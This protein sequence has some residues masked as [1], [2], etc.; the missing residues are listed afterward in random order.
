MLLPRSKD[1]GG[2]MQMAGKEK[3]IAIFSDTCHG[4][5]ATSVT[6]RTTATG[7]VVHVVGAYT[8]ATGTYTYVFANDGTVAVQYAFTVTA[9]GKCDPRQIGVVFRLPKDCDQLTWRRKAQWSAYPDD[10]IG[11]PQGTATAFV[12]GV[13]L[14]GLAGPRTAPTW[15]WSADANQYGCNDF[16][17]TK[18]NVFEAALLSPGGKGVRVLSDGSQHARS[19][20]TGNGVSLLVAEYANHGSPSFFGE[21]VIPNRPLKAGDNITG[22]IRL[23]VR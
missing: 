8:E 12:R 16:R 2:G 23:E 9:K 3:D 18:M 7:I 20:V 19:W 6:T 5:R 14:S 11:R 13:P 17:S 10:H 22:T 15:S 4:W 1:S 21:H